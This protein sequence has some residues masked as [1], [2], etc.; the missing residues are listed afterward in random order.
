MYVSIVDWLL[1]NRHLLVLSVALLLAAGLAAWSSL[2]RIEDPRITTRN[3]TLITSLPGASAARVETLVTKKLEDALR[4]VPEIKTIESTSRGGVSVISIE[5]D[6]A[7]DARTNEQVFSKVRDKLAAAERLLPPEAG[8]PVLDD[9]RGAVAY[10]LIAAVTWEGTGEPRLGIL[11]RVADELADRLRNIQGTE[12]A[13]VFGGT[14]EEIQV[15]L[16]AG[17]LA[18]LGLTVA[19]VAERLSAADAKLPAGTLRTAGH[20]IGLGV[21]G[22]LDAAARVASVPLAAGPRGVV[23]VGDV[24]RVTRRWREPPAQAA[25]ADGK[26]AVLVGVRTEEA[27]H[28]DDWSARARDQVAGFAEGVGDGVQLRVVFDQ[29]RYTDAR[30]RGLGGNLAAGAVVVMFV[31]F[32]AMGWRPALIVGAALPLSA[33]ITLFGLDL[34]GQQIHQ[35]SIFGMII[36]IGLL[37]DNAIVMTEEVRK[38]LLEGDTP[39]VAA[40]AAVSYLAAPLSASTFT[41]VLGFMPI[42]LLPGNVGDFVRPIAVSVILALIASFAIAMTLIPVLAALLLRPIAT[43]RWWTDGWS[44]PRLAVAYRRTLAMAVRRPLVTTAA[45]LVL[46]IAGFVAAG[47]LGNQFFPTSDRD[48]FEV[49]VWLA[50]DAPLERTADTVLAMEDVIRGAGDV[51][52]VSWVVGASSPPVYYNQLRDQD[53]NPAHARATVLAAD[54]EEAKKLVSVLQD[55]LSD[56]FPEARVV[57]RAFGQGPPIAAPISLR[58][59]GPDTDRLRIYGEEVRRIMHRLPEITHTA[60]SIQ[61]GEPKLWLDAD[62]EEARLAGLTLGGIAGQFQNALEGAVGGRVLEDL[63]DLPVR[64]RYATM[65]RGDTARLATLRLVSP[66]APDGWVPA[67]A[68]GELKLR[69]ETASITRRNGERVNRVEG[70]IR[71][72]ALPI[73][74]TRELQQHMADEGFRLAP[75]YRLELAGDSAEQREAVGLLLAYAPLLACLML[76]SLVSS[77]RSFRIAGIIGVVAILSVGLGMLSLWAGGYP[78]GFNPIL[79]T[80]GLVGVAI[81]ASI[82]ILAAIRADPDAHNG[83][84]AAIVRETLGAT[85]HIVSTT[86]TTVAGF[87]PLLFFSGGDFWPPLAVVIAG[88]V[89]LS[90][91][92]G[93]MLT[94]AAYRLILPQREPP[95]KSSAAPASGL[96]TDV[97]RAG[98]CAAPPHP[99]GAV[100][101]GPRSRSRC[102]PS[103][104]R[105][106]GL[107]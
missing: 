38:R 42:F 107:G 18:A 8:K 61:G 59:V 54:Y 15:E 40:R 11:N 71:P 36:A 21:T 7:V 14:E 49:Q 46:P 17:E 79:G 31:V 78:L 96:R 102:P 62:E 53:D 91:T 5:L 28:L 22:E 52:G 44:S 75:G 76:A 20:R 90:I 9:K 25:F 100:R 56:R 1:G 104:M 43:G 24:A 80:A 55:R 95:P 63:E 45:C 99:M 19:D 47:S 81:N 86:L 67:Q 106:V 35:M 87:L 2:P 60:A 26:R 13:L 103:P 48:Q 51:R 4:E 37:I 82:V 57:V 32:V 16:D 65:E 33:A 84:P 39:A 89:G 41:T 98:R 77:F 30:L 29:S 10:S 64:V 101:T 85:R 72:D 66:A 27:V 94:P 58:L 50:P 3:A 12:Q 6:S 92:L 23:S 70:W 88:G 74:V 68:L 83:D 73:D 34:A 97:G 93:L 105:P 69:P